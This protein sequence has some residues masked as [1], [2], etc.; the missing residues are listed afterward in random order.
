MLEL[1]M[2]DYVIDYIES[3]KGIRI[4]QN[5]VDFRT[6]LKRVDLFGE[7]KKYFYAIEMKREG[8]PLSEIEKDYANLD[9]IIKNNNIGKPI[10]GIL[11]AF[12]DNLSLI[13]KIN[14]NDNIEII[15]FDSECFKTSKRGTRKYLSSEYKYL[16]YIF[17][18]IE[19]RELI[20]FKFSK[21][22]LEVEYKVKYKNYLYLGHYNSDKNAILGDLIY[23]KNDEDGR[24]LYFIEKENVNYRRLDEEIRKLKL[25]SEYDSETIAY[26]SV[27]KI[28][29]FKQF[30]TLR[31]RF[32]IIHKNR[33]FE[34]FI[35]LNKKYKPVIE[36][37][38]QEKNREIYRVKLLNELAFYE[39][40]NV[41]IGKKMYRPIINMCVG[42]DFN[43]IKL[44]IEMEKDNCYKEITLYKKVKK[45][46]RIDNISIYMMLDPNIIAKLEFEIY[47]KMKSGWR[48]SEEYYSL[49]NTELYNKYKR[50]YEAVYEEEYIKARKVII[51]QLLM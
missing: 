25:Y 6:C 32:K 17:V 47:I 51:E 18:F 3:E 50:E 5:E 13:K 4:L 38:K 15:L 20:S 1:D 43:K 44:T 39:F 10:K 24:R 46:K 49:A 14:K 40:N 9:I 36:N 2:Y 27:E 19:S 29:S 45:I 7:D 33:G 26:F 23:I 37:S 28:L 35:I 31:D 22:K 16:R 12:V 42:V 48:I 21:N 8:V 34:L 11:I 30:R 41:I